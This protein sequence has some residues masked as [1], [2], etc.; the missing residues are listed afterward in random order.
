[1]EKKRLVALTSFA[2]G[3]GV[4]V[5]ATESWAQCLVMK[6]ISP[7]PPVRVE[8]P[9]K[10][11]ATQ[12]LFTFTAGLTGACAGVVKDTVSFTFSGGGS[13]VEGKSIKPAEKTLSVGL[14]TAVQ[15][16]VRVTRDAEPDLYS[17][18]ITGT[19]IISGKD[20]I[21]ASVVVEEPDIA[22]ELD[23]VEEPE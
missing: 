11:F 20:E 18:L 12:V 4:M 16:T 6:Q 15:F 3:L 22:E 7:I 14:E 5:V 19:S 10:C 17:F 13:G 2:I 23:I 8:N 21:V 9:G 1:M